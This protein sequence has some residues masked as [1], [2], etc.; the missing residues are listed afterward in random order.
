MAELIL[1]FSRPG[2]NYVNGTIKH[3]SVG[4]TEVA[5][6]ILQEITKGDLFKLDPMSPYS[7]DY[8]ECIDEAKRDQ[9]RNARPELKAYPENLDQYGTIYL[10]YP[11]YWGTMP[12]QYSPFWSTSTSAAKP[13][14]LFAPTKGAAWEEAKAT[15]DSFVPAGLA[16]RGGNV[17]NA[18]DTLKQWV[19]QNNDSLK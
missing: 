4:N 5:A 19:N 16:L 14:S 13:L 8:S 3:L 1:Y 18:S 12:M 6:K 11:N 2:N 10:G 9:Q 17:V 15:S 7:S